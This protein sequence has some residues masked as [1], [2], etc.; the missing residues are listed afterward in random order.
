MLCGGTLSNLTITLSGTPSSGGGTQT[1]AVAVMVDG[2]ASALTC[3]VGDASTTCT[4]SGSITL[5]SGQLVNVRITPSG[6]PSARTATWSS[7][8][9]RG[10]GGGQ[11]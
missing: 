7:T 5:T 6:P 8:Y 10:T 11:L 3:T 1:Y 4:T 2:A 9:V